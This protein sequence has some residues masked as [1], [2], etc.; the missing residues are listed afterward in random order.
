MVWYPRRQHLKRKTNRTENQYDDI[1]NRLNFPSHFTA[2]CNLKLPNAWACVMQF[3]YRVYMN[4]KYLEARCRIPRTTWRW[5]SRMCRTS[6]VTSFRCRDVRVVKSKAPYY[7]ITTVWNSKVWQLFQSWDQGRGYM[8]CHTPIKFEK[9]VK[10][11]IVCQNAKFTI[12]LFWN[13]IL[14]FEYKN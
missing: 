2:S 6:N 4:V 7:P 11:G 10:L 14:K 1:H 3:I 12:T 9:L 5:S 13:K 8:G